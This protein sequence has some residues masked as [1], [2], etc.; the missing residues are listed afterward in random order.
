MTTQ[1]IYVSLGNTR[2]VGGV[3]TDITGKDISADT[4]AIATVLGQ[5]N[6]NVPPPAALFTTLGTDVFAQGL[7]VASKSV[8]RLIDTIGNYP[9]GTY[10]CW[11]RVTDNPE[12]EP[13]LLQTFTTA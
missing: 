6:A 7:T 12:I 9:A 11:V 13:I 1:N 8:K 5:L 10:G 3:V 2:Y 4:Y